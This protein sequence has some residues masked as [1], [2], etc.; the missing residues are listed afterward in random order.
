MHSHIVASFQRIGALF[1]SKCLE[2]L[3][4]GVIACTSVPKLRFM[5]MHIYTRGSGH[6]GP[7][8]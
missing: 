8:G 6:G 2:S 4:D 7:S 1:K 5:I 3:G